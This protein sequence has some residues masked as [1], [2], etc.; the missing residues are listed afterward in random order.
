MGALGESAPRAEVERFFRAVGA[1]DLRAYVG[2][3]ASLVG[4]RASDI[5][6]RVRVP[7]LVVAPERDVMALRGDLVAL[8]EAIPGAE[9]LELPGTSHAVLLEAGSTIADRVRAFVAAHA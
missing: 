5:L 9:W 7:V 3:L 4:A 1:M 6:P 8:R 2:T